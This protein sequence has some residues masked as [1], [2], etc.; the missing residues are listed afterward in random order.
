MGAAL[1]Q[2]RAVDKWRGGEVPAA[3]PPAGDP[4]TTSPTYLPPAYLPPPGLPPLGVTS[5]GVPSHAA[6]GPQG[7]DTTHTFVLHSP[8]ASAPDDARLPAAAGQD[9]V[10]PP[11]T[12]PPGLAAD[13]SGPPDD[14]H[15]LRTTTSPL[16]A[17]PPPLPRIRRTPWWRRFR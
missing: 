12:P 8:T 16:D 9:S 1:A 7:G 15:P 17:D 4:G 6:A 2:A 14:D 3:A 10:P 11:L 5:L 13:W